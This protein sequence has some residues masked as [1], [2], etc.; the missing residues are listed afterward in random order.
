LQVIEP[1]Q[2]TREV[3]CA[4]HTQDYVNKFFNGETSESE[5]RATGFVWTPGLASRVKYETG[6]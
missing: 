3:V 5:Q 2:V 1:L 4:V 6:M